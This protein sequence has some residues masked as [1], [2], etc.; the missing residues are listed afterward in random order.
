MNTEKILEVKNLKVFYGSI[1]AVKGVS[2]YVKPGEIVSLI[3]CNGAGKTSILRALCGAAKS[4]GEVI[5]NG[6]ALHSL[7]IDK[8]V[9]EG[10]AAS[11]EGRGVFPQLSVY[12]NLLMGAYSR[13]DFK[14]TELDEIFILFPRLKD[15][16]SQLAGTLSGGE[17]QMLSISRALLAQ[18]KVLLLDEPSLGLAPLIVAQIFEIIK[19]LNSRGVTILLVEQNAKQALKISHRAYVIETGLLVLEDSGLNLLNNEQ[20]QKSYLGI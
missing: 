14:L 18:P 15:R 8:R 3:G 9:T 4:S 12:E 2:F 10:L 20:V 16:I 13:N 1:E 7:S 6:N 5:L 17:Q 19:T 11:P